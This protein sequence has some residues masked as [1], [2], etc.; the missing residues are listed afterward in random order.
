MGQ[1]GYGI[2]MFVLGL[3]LLPLFF[4]FGGAGGVITEVIIFSIILIKHAKMYYSSPSVIMKNID[5]NIYKFGKEYVNTHPNRSL[6]YEEKK[7]N[8]IRC[9]IYEIAYQTSLKYGRDYISKYD[10]K[11]AVDSVPGVY[12]NNYGVYCI[13]YGSNRRSIDIYLIIFPKEF[14]EKEPNLGPHRK[15]LKVL[16]K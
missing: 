8:D 14:R 16:Y 12:I 3:A 4:M 10:Y 1:E 7:Y 5:T 6:T 15:R 9:V 11:V 13:S 2:T